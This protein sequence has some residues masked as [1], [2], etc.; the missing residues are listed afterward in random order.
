M[1]KTYPPFYLPL[2]EVV[3][4]LLSYQH[5]RFDFSGSGFYSKE[6]RQNFFYI[7]LGPQL[8][9]KAFLCMPR[10]FLYRNFT[11]LNV[12]IYLFI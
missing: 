4:F 7:G 5:D 12:I 8:C 1:Y 6:I 11:R 2:L 3:T 9:E 10:I